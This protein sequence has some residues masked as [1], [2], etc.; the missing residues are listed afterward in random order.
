M[1]RIQKCMRILASSMAYE[2]LFP[3]NYRRNICIS[4]MDLRSQLILLGAQ[5]FDEQ[6]SFQYCVRINPLLIYR[7]LLCQVLEEILEGSTLQCALTIGS[8]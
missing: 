3:R 7:V 1:Q 5:L 6:Q 4:L 8:C 2:S